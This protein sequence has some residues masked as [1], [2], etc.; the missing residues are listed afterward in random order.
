MTI[1]V[2]AVIVELEY[3]YFVEPFIYQAYDDE[4]KLLVSTITMRCVAEQN[5]GLDIEVS[6]LDTM[7]VKLTGN[8]VLKSGNKSKRSDWEWLSYY[9]IQNQLKDDDLRETLL[10]TMRNAHSNFTTFVN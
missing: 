6:P 3:N 10:T 9:R 7:E 8:I 4:P 5:E 1:K 2:D